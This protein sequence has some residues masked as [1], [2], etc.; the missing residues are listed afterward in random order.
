M[1]ARTSR[2]FTGLQNFVNR[3]SAALNNIVYMEPV[4]PTV[5]TALTVGE[6][7]SNPEVYGMYTNPY[8]LKKGQVVE[9]ILNNDDGGKHP[10][11]LH[12]HN[13][14]I[15]SRS[16][17]DAGDFNATAAADPI[18]DYPIKRDT[19]TVNPTGNLRVRFVADN[20]GIWLFHCHIEW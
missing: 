4:V 19:V 1:M 10:F 11:H 9:I 6:N 15:I 2:F 17:D 16:A 5:F 7:A 8:I 12:G 13:F 3:C 18:P 14:Q 20:P